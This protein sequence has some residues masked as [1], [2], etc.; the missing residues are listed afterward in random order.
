MVFRMEWPPKSGKEEEFPEI[1]KVEWF[2]IPRAERRILPG[3]RRSSRSCG[4]L[5]K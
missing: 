1:D 3:R 2:A 5:V 4:S